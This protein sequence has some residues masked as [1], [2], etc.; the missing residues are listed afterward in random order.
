KM[1]NPTKN[2]K[3][4][5]YLH[6]QLVGNITSYI[7]NHRFDE[8]THSEACPALS[9]G[10]SSGKFVRPLQ[11]SG[12]NIH[13]RKGEIK[14]AFEFALTEFERF[15]K[16]GA[17]ASELKRAKASIKNSYI[18]YL[19][20]E[21]N[22]SNDSYAEDLYAHFF[23]G[24]PL[25]TLKWKVDYIIDALKTITN[26]DIRQYIRENYNME[27]RVLA[28]KGNSEAPYPSEKEFK[29]VIK[30]VSAKNLTAYKDNFAEKELISKD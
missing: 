26:K 24:H 25:P 29:Q 14:E 8:L 12:L 10:Y 20:N 16:Y 6:R 21:K 3:G 28:V 27:N 22:I 18:T 1:K 17:T 4:K 15:V 19:N 11:I 7:L 23:T 5:A 30:T 13:P 9:V 2:L